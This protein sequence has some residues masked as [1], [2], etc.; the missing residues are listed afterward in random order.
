MESIERGRLYDAYRSWK[1]VQSVDDSDETKATIRSLKSALILAARAYLRDATKLQAEGKM[2]EVVPLL[3]EVSRLEGL[4]EAQLAW[5]ILLENKDEIDALKLMQIV[6]GILASAPPEAQPAPEEEPTSET[7][8][9]DEDPQAVDDAKDSNEDDADGEGDSTE[10]VFC[11]DPNCDGL[12]TGQDAN[13]LLGLAP[14][15]DATPPTRLELASR[16]SLKHQRMIITKLEVLTNYYKHTFIST[17]AQA[18]LEELQADERLADAFSDEVPDDDEAATGDSAAEPREM[19]LANMYCKGELFEKARALYEKVIEDHPDTDYAEQAKQGIA[20]IE[21]RLRL[22]AEA[23]AEAARAA[24]AEA[25]N[26]R[27]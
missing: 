10:G 26:R 23:E 25:N 11:D 7:D 1:A 5:D 27:Y 12:H 14:L 4:R 24:E 19:R 16:L 3:R 18:F 13:E 22:A 17:E 9:S 21:E 6:D 8:A 15:P 20:E 2:G